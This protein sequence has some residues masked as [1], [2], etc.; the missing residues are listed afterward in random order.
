MR[1]TFFEDLEQDGQEVALHQLRLALEQEEVPQR[2]GGRREVGVDGQLHA[3]QVQQALEVEDE[4][5]HAVEQQQFGGTGQREQQVQVDANQ[6][7]RQEEQGPAE[8]LDVAQVDHALADVLQ[9]E[10]LV[11]AYER[12]RVHG[13]FAPELLERE[14][15]VLVVGLAAQQL[16]G[17]RVAGARADGAPVLVRVVEAEPHEGDALLVEREEEGQVGLD[18]PEALGFG[19]GGSEG[20]VDVGEVA[21]AVL[22]HALADR[23]GVRSGRVGPGVLAS[24]QKRDLE[25]HEKVEVL[26]LQKL[27]FLDEEDTEE[28][29]VVAG[30]GAQGA[31]VRVAGVQVKGIDQVDLGFGR[32]RRAGP[33]AR[34][35]SVDLVNEI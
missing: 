16:E 3:Q 1:A 18:A 32:V 21:E 7:R 10:R 8:Q 29:H 30:D 35:R 33:R 2:V 4:D 31:Q 28:V 27:V 5:G 24:V 20:Q 14:E 25:H 17:L 12:G 15:E 23:V 9:P 11:T 6:Q 19:V 26:M 22:L 34:F 13:G